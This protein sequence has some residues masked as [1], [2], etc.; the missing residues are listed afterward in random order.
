MAFGPPF[1]LDQ[2][3]PLT[4]ELPQVLNYFDFVLVVFELYVLCKLGVWWCW[5]QQFLVKDRVDA[6]AWWQPEFVVYRA[7]FL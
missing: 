3:L 5:F 2:V 6:H 4:S 7:Y 1:P